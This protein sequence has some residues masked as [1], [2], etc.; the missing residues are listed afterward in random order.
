MVMALQPAAAAVLVQETASG[1]KVV[2]AL[3]RMAE[4]EYVVYTASF[5]VLIKHVFQSPAVFVRPVALT[6]QILQQHRD[7]C[8]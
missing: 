8:H 6:N 4:A 1:V 5:R 3:L 2:S 7:S